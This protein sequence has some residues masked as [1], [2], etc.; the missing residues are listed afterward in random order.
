MHDIVTIATLVEREA[1]R[2]DERARIAGVIYNRLNNSSERFQYLR[3]DPSESC[4]VWDA[5]AA[6]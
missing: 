2:D 1:Q 6:S 5:P 4:M 3:V